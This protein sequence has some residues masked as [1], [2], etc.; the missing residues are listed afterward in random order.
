MAFLVASTPPEKSTR[1]LPHGRVA[2]LENAHRMALTVPAEKNLWNPVPAKTAATRHKR[3]LREPGIRENAPHFFTGLARG[4]FFSGETTCLVSAQ[5]RGARRFSSCADADSCQRPE[6]RGRLDHATGWRTAR[7]SSRR[8][9]RSSAVMPPRIRTS[10]A[11]SPG[12]FVPSFVPGRIASLVF[13]EG[14]P[15][16]SVPVSPMEQPVRRATVRCCGIRFHGL[17]YA[18]E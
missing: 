5:P 1:T 2:T 7:A 6:R 13:P 4:F 17:A 10:S 16:C 18:I 14:N 8:A 11:R 9:T 12:S 15:L 3:P